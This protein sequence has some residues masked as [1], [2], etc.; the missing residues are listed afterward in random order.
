MNDP[1]ACD[2]FVS[3]GLH[4]TASNTPF[5]P[6]TRRPCRT[7]RL[8]RGT[9]ERG[10]NPRRRQTPDPRPYPDAQRPPTTECR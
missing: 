2:G 1:T 7:A 4:G 9:T 5:A 3:Y 10:R 6:R 8:P